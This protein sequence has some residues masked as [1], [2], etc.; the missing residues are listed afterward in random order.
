MAFLDVDVA[1]MCCQG[2]IARSWWCKP[3]LCLSSNSRYAGCLHMVG[4]G[5][6]NLLGRRY[7]ICGL[8]HRRVSG[9]CDTNQ[10]PQYKCIHCVGKHLKTLLSPLT[11]PCAKCK[12]R[13]NTS[14]GGM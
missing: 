8:P 11:L 5:T 14:A 9:M 7:G 12:T 2:I 6:A 10:V 4:V 3:S 13:C 1:G